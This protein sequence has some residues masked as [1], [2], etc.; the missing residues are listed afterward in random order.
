MTKKEEKICDTVNRTLK[1]L[2]AKRYVI[3]FNRQYLYSNGHGG[4]ESKASRMSRS[5]F[6]RWR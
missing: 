3:I 5:P 2:E 1:K 6:A 4:Y